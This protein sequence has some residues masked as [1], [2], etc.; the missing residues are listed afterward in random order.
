MPHANGPAEKL[1]LRELEVLKLIASG[2]STK[3]I[4]SSLKITFKTAACHRMRM[5]DKLA[6]HRVADLTRYA[7]RHG[8][9]DLG[10]NGNSGDRQS[11]LFERIKAT[12]ATYRKAMDDY[13]AFI[14]DRP[15]LGLNNPDGVTG[16][17]RLRQAEEGAHEE[18]HAALIALKNFLLGEGNKPEAIQRTPAPEFKKWGP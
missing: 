15:M 14:K 9:V 2:L 17:R 3:E 13:G 11:E 5:M 4:A 6:I 1:T 16:A 12:E 8:Y 7:I 10:G 18:Y